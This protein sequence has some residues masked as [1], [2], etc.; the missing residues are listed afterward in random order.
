M[1]LLRSIFPRSALLLRSNP[2]Q[3]QFQ[4]RHFASREEVNQALKLI[5]KNPKEFVEK[6]VADDV[7]WTVTEPAGK[8]TPISGKCSRFVR[9][10][11]KQGNE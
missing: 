11:G 7:L 8:S 1:L 6:Y 3:Q 9:L 10:G 2:L 5:E 4:R